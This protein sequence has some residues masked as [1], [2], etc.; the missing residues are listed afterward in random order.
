MPSTHPGRE[1]YV[2]RKSRLFCMRIIV[3]LISIAGSIICLGFAFLALAFSGMS[4]SSTGPAAG[5]MV[6]FGV[7]P[8]MYL[9]YCCFSTFNYLTQRAL[10]ISGVV[11]HLTILPLIVISLRS[12]ST[13]IIGIGAIGMIAC[14]FGMYFEKKTNK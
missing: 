3:R 4:D 7:I 6:V 9:I 10:L 13:A 2:R 12:S 5:P 14:W 8:F 1:S 11:A